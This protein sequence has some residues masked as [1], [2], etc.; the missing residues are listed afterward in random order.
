MKIF[1]MNGKK[2]VGYAFSII[3]ISTVFFLANM[4]TLNVVQTSSKSSRLL[5]IYNIETAEKKISLTFDSAWGT[6]DIDI[7]LKTLK[8]NEVRATFF[9]LG[10]WARKNPEVIKKMVADGHDVANHSD[11]HPH[12]T[13]LSFEKIKEDMR[14][15]NKSIE[16]ISGKKNNLYRAPYGE[17]NDNVIKAATE[18]GYYT[19]QWD[20]D[21]LDWKDPGKDKIIDRVVKKVKPGSIVL[22]HNG[23]KD[24]A[25]ALLEMITK[26][27]AEGYSFAPISEFIYKENYT[28]DNSGKQIKNN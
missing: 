25:N 15:A 17:Y 8:D 9:V 5:P 7:I 14:A 13:S 1:V 10:E 22:L 4:F 18:E 23:T 12:V 16:E 24:T 27:K 3:A 6:E 20:V 2:F 11:T 28:I 19:I 26:L 21:S